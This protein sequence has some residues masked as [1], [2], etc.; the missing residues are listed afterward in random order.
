MEL[1]LEEE[2][3]QFYSE[4]QTDQSSVVFIGG[5]TYNAM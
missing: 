5:K 2:K 4:A 1:K 3:T